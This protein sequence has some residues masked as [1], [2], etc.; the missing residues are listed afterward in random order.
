[1]IYKSSYIKCTI[2]NIFYEHEH[3]LKK[4]IID[5]KKYKLIKCINCKNYNLFGFPRRFTVTTN[6]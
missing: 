1:M 4:D 2:C 3:F 5:M 6:I